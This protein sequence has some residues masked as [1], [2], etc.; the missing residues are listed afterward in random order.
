MSLPK[1]LLALA[2]PLA[3]SLAVLLAAGFE[4]SPIRD[5]ATL[6]PVA[7]AHVV[8]PLGYVAVAP[9]SNVLDT[10]TLLSARQ[11]IALAAG[12]LVLFALWRVL[13]HFLGPAERRWRP[14]LIA[15]AILLGC[16]VLA[17]AATAALPR[18]MAYL[19][20]AES[21]ILRVDF[22]SHTSASR[23][24][25]PGWTAR[26]S[27]D[28]HRQAGYDV[29][30][31]T[32]HA[33][34]SAAEVG[35]AG[36]PNPAAEGVT[37]LQGIEVTWT[38]EHVV[39][40]GA[41]RAYRGLLT[42]NMRDVDPQSMGLASIIAGSEPVVVWN[43]PR[44][45]DRLPVMRAAVTPSVRAIEIVNGAPQ[46]MDK[47]RPKRSAIVALASGRNVALTA[48]SDNHG[49]GRAAPGWTLMRIVG[50][51]GMY[52]DSLGRHIERAIREAGFGATR[53]VERRVAD[54]GGS[55]AALAASVVTIPARMLTTLS[56]DERMAWLIW[57]W[58]I[59]I[60][61]W[62]VRRSS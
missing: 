32:D 35:M 46:N 34:V 42:P 22:H 59:T 30:L 60:A 47:V 4:V 20:T 11:H 16:I 57:T 41:E 5:A 39:I 54:P 50:W 15:F 10:L 62:R 38:G 52:G 37:L 36:N 17:Y 58:L 25:R 9:L 13:A 48:G 3:I 44:D 23:D 51:R 27:R 45:L 1:R 53:V 12:V 55:R 6:A 18:P 21:H 26:R 19:E 2:A 49:W 28:W 14:H 56:P 8:R 7:E 43:H 61:A 33:A 24:G 40:I 31:I 29:A